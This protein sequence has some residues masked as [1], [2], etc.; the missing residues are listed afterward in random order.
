MNEPAALT[1]SRDEAMIEAWGQCASLSIEGDPCTDDFRIL[2]RCSGSRLDAHH[3]QKRSAGGSHTTDN[4]MALCVDCHRRVHEQAGRMTG[5]FDDSLGRRYYFDDI[6]GAREIRKVRIYNWRDFKEHLESRFI[7]AESV[8]AAGSRWGKKGQWAAGWAFEEMDRLGLWQLD[9]DLQP[10]DT[11]FVDY[12]RNRG[13]GIAEV[14]L[15]QYTNVVSV[16]RE[17]GVQ[18]DELLGAVDICGEV[19]SHPAGY[20][21]VRDNLPAIRKMDREQIVSLLETT[22]SSDFKATVHDRIEDAE[23]AAAIEQGKTRVQMDTTLTVEIQHTFTSMGNESLDR[24]KLE[25]RIRQAIGKRGV[26]G[27][28]RFKHHSRVEVG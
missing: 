3:V 27:S 9:A 8:L 17:A 28:F 11:T 7:E 25:G 21:S 12:L 20:S 26:P 4:I 23:T 19:H 15:N 6:G 10:E 2:K 16:L 1:R 13:L 14:T 5:P 18:L 24:A 22:P